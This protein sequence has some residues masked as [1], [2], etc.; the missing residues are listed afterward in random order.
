MSVI[1]SAYLFNYKKFKEEA[2]LLVRFADNGD[3]KPLLERAISIVDGLQKQHQEWIIEDTFG[4]PLFDVSKWK[5]PLTPWETGYCFLLVLS[6]YLQSPPTDSLG[7]ISDRPFL[8]A[9]LTAT[10]WS[11][12]DAILLGDDF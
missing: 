3:G 10:D 9:G 8:H 6:D 11:E 4:N 1:H 5:I 12:R 2:E 7:I